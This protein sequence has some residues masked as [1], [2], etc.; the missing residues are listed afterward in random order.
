MY[1]NGSVEIRIQDAKV[2]DWRTTLECDDS[3]SS[4]SREQHGSNGADV[5][6]DLERSHCSVGSCGRTA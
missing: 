2:Q 4:D 1:V 3:S 6:V 5:R